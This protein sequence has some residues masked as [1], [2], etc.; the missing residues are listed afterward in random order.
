M[1][2]YELGCFHTGV[3]SR[4]SGNFSGPRSPF[5]AETLCTW[6]IKVSAG[7]QI[8]LNFKYRSV[9]QRDCSF[10]Y[11]EVYDGFSPTNKSLGRFCKYYESRKIKSKHSSMYVTLYVDSTFRSNGVP[12][13]YSEYTVSSDTGEV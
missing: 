12:Y 9:T 13:F 7:L 5:N 10:A 2:L 8:E 3:L 6:L 11:V 4:Q 1:N